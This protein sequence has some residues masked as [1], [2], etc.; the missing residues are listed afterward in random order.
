[1]SLLWILLNLLFLVKWRKLCLLGLLPYSLDGHYPAF[2][3]IYLLLVIFG[4]LHIGLVRNCVFYFYCFLRNEN[5]FLLNQVYRKKNNRVHH[6]HLQKV[7]LKWMRTFLLK[8]ICPNKYYPPQNLTY[9]LNKI[10]NFLVKLR[11]LSS[12]DLFQ[13]QKFV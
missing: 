6:H 3:W 13:T 7:C 11:I 1:M 12:F 2:F 8:R 5:E 4:F 10:I 9:Y